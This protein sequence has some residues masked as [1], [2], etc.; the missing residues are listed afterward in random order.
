[1]CIKNNLNK[2]NINC[3]ILSLACVSPWISSMVVSTTTET[4]CSDFTHRCFFFFLESLM[5]LHVWCNMTGLWLWLHIKP[6]K[7]WNSASACCN[8]LVVGRFCSHFIVC[9]SSSRNTCRS[10]TGSELSG[11]C[12]GWSE[13]DY[14]STERTLFSLLPS[15]LFFLFF[16]SQLRAILFYL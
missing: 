3:D 8:H 4:T 1:M 13:R 9:S 11:L 16:D 2:P 12:C 10:S 6:N 15:K 14:V 7:A 5:V